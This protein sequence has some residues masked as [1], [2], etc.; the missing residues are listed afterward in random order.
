MPLSRVK[1]GSNMYGF[2]PC[3]GQPPKVTEWRPGCYGAQC[4][5]CGRIAGNERQLDERGLREE[6]NR[7]LRDMGVEVREKANLGRVLAW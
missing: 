7:G 6:W 3:C 1:D 5:E 4:M 2:D